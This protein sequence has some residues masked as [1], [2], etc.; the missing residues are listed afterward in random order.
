MKVERYDWDTLPP[1]FGPRELAKF[2]GIGEA[3]AYSLAKRKG[4]PALRV[5][6][7]FRIS[8]EGLREWL[9]RELSG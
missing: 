5:G 1:F 8:R 4:F 9:Q 7:K 3:A 2:L 6:R